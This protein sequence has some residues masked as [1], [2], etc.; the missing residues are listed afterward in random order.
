MNTL[1]LLFSSFFRT[2]AILPHALRK[3]V[4]VL[5]ILMLLMGLLELGSI[6]SLSFFAA[7]L[8]SPERI[9]DSRHMAALFAHVPGLAP[10]FADARYIMLYAAFLPIGLI[11]MKNLMSSLVTWRTGLLGSEAA[12]YVGSEIM[13][14]FVHMP[15]DWHLSS[16]SADAFT[17]L[18]W[19]HSLGQ[20]LLNNLVAYSNF[21]VA[22]L[23]FLGL[24]F[25]SPG[26]TLFVLCVM[27]L[28]AISLYCGIRER[29][30]RASC[31]LA[32][33]QGEESRASMAAVRGIREIL[34][35][36]QQPVF[37]R[38]IAQGMAKGVLPQAFLSFA[39]PIPT[40][41]LESVGFSLIGLTLAWL[42]FVQDADRTAIIASIAMLTLTA[43]RVLPS[44]NRAVG[45]VV[46][47]RANKP[48]GISA[49][50][51]TG[52]ALRGAFALRSQHGSRALAW[53]QAG[54]CAAARPGPF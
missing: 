50:E 37:L 10:L 27:A 38:A 47:I 26:M 42:V 24:F 4:T 17:K 30:D 6:V 2:W 13:R 39:P 46:N 14:R 33:A 44:L 41:V 12:N 28:V 23:L 29:I 34:I 36:Q 11:I 3:N 5:F 43:W 54:T 32:Q 40:W 7:V 8:H 51:R 22:G 15:Y 18:S 9:Q 19:R 52:D 35:Y 20:L 1:R 53:L 21:I 31:S 25:Y 45:A 49:P 48:M 16:L